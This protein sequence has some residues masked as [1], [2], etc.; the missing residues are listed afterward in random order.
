MT[1][2]SGLKYFVPRKRVTIYPRATH[3]DI[4]ALFACNN[5]Y[6]K[7]RHYNLSTQLQLE[8]CVNELCKPVRRPV[9]PIMHQNYISIV[10]F[11]HGKNIAGSLVFL[12]CFLFCFKC[13]KTE[14]IFMLKNPYFIPG[15]KH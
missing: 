14:S 1:R 12:S 15:E 2:K 7:L 8:L 10:T 3:S 11:D 6:I 9:C 13:H 4:I 5:L